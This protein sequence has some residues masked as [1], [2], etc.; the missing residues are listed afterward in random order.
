M[1]YITEYDSVAKINLDCILGADI[2]IKKVMHGSG[3]SI[4][5][6]V[7]AI[8]KKT[9][10][11]FIIKI[12]PRTIYYNVKIYPN[13]DDLEMAFYY[14]FTK[15]YVQTNRTPHIVGIYSSIKCPDLESIIKQKIMGMSCP[16]ITS[17]LKS[18]LKSRHRSK[19]D[20]TYK[21]DYLCD[22]LLR[23]QM[24][25]ID[26]ECDMILLEYCPDDFSSVLEQSLKKISVSKGENLEKDVSGL[27]RLLYRLF[28]QIIFTLTIIK[29]DYEG[30]LHGDFFLRNILIRS[31]SAYKSTD[32]VSYQ[33][34]SNIFY[35]PAN[36]FY[37]K[38]NDFGM[39]TIANKIEP[40]VFDPNAD[41]R[42]VLNGQNYNPFSKKTDLYNFFIDLYDELLFIE[43]EENIHPVKLQS[44]YKL[45]RKFFNTDTIDKIPDKDYLSSIWHI[46]GIDILTS[47]LKTPPEYLMGKLFDQFKTLPVGCVVIKKFN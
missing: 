27:V 19:S 31:E 17:K 33:Y 7:L 12:F 35:L 10:A 20:Q 40:N 5:I 32:Y 25:M 26:S 42:R 1:N 4:N 8:S 2:E 37:A 15:Q 3:G 41:P 47:T 11:E 22:I 29:D 24:K 23:K 6:I 43:E 38:I 30:F 44:V 13:F 16:T 45:I 9:G 46:E 39:T 28:F 34:K 14:F 36:G 21:T 18:K